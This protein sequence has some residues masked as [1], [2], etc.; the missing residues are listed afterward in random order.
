MI[1]TA[2]LHI[3]DVAYNASITKQ[4]EYN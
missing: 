3:T 4:L 1:I 2:H